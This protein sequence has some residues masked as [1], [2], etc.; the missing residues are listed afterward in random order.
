MVKGK[1]GGMH[2]KGEG[3]RNGKGEGGRWDTL[4]IVQCPTM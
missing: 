4:Q 2:G 1:E 3:G